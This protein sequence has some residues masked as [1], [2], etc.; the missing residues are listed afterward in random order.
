MK[1]LRKVCHH[2][3][4]DILAQIFYQG[5]DIS[6]DVEISNLLVTDSCG[7]QADAIDAKFANS[8]NQWSEWKPKKED[9]LNIIN[10]GYRSGSMWIDRIRQEDNLVVL[11]AVSIPPG[12]KTK[13]TKAWENATLITIA[14]ERAAQYGLTAQFLNVPAFTYARVD[15]VGRGDFGFLQ[16]RAMLEGCSIKVQDKRLFVYSDAYM[17]G[18]PAVKT[19]DAADFFEE[20]RFSDSSGGTYHSCTVAWQSFSGTYTDPDAIGPEL[21]V[22]TYPVFSAGESQRFAKN[23]LRSYNKKGD[24]GEISV[25]LDTGITAGNSVNITGMGLSDGKYFIDT[26]QHNFAEEVSRFTMHRC[27]TR[28]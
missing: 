2:G 10:A 4:G 6:A 15:Q 7:D 21:A 20:P 5:K 3:R 16:E 18:L 8:E 22:N 28:Y 26:A 19:I 12:G 11:G 25:M 24:I 13:R 17:E 14:A 23:I 27:F 9:V 1:L